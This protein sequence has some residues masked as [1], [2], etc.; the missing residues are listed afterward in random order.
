[1]RARASERLAVGAAGLALVLSA[2]GALQAV[3][4][5]D[6]ARVRLDAVRGKARALEQE[7]RRLDQAAGRDARDLQERAALTVGAAPAGVISHLADT[8]PPD[9]RIARLDM[10]YGQALTLDLRVEA[11]SP[12]A[13]DRFLG[14]LAGSGRLRDI[15]TGPEAR[16]GEVVA[17]VRAIYRPGGAP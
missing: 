13:Y 1:L 6:A 17:S 9:V 10:V 5:R 14:A 8:L 16:E 11:R 7:A 4:S 15:E 2:A 3:R 12:Q